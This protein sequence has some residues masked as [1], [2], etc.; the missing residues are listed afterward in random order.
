MVEKNATKQTGKNAQ[1]LKELRV[2]RAK[3][4]D[5]V[6]ELLKAQRRIISLIEKALKDGPKTVPEIS[7]ITSLPSHEVLW[8]IASLKKYGIVAEAEKRESYFAYRLTLQDTEQEIN[9]E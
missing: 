6:R 8:W 3:N 9:K 2:K 1:L 5:R 7:E 4:I